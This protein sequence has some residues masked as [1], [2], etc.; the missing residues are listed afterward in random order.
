MRQVESTKITHKICDM[1]RENGIELHALEA[2]KMA[3]IILKYGDMTYDEGHAG[4]REAESHKL[5]DRPIGHRPGIDA[6]VLIQGE[7]AD[8]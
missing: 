6:T 4:W 8:D 5:A 3:N 2:E 1:L 7:P